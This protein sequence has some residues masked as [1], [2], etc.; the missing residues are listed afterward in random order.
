MPCELMNARYSICPAFFQARFQPC[1]GFSDGSDSR[2]RF[3]HCR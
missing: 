2:S 1:Q 3:A